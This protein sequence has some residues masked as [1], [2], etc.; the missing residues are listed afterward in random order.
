MTWSS[1]HFWCASSSIGPSRVS[2]PQILDFLQVGLNA[3]LAVNTLRQQVSVLATVLACKDHGLLSQHPRICCFLWGASN[4]RPPTVHRYPSW[5]LDLI[6]QVLEDSPF[7]PLSSVSLKFLT[8]KMAFL[9][10][11]TSARQVSALTALSIHK[12]LCI[13]HL[14]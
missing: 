11:V 8:F 2:I 1:F 9:V 13:F 7:K 3:R 4:L 10:A 6:R 12:G 5:D 14:D